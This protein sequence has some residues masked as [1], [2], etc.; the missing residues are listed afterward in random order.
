MTDEEMEEL[1]QKAAQEEI[2]M[3][4]DLYADPIELRPPASPEQIAQCEAFLG[5]AFP[6][7]YRHFLSLHNGFKTKHEW[8]F[9][10]TEDYKTATAQRQIALINR[11]G[12]DVEDVDVSELPDDVFYPQNLYPLLD[13]KV[14]IPEHLRYLKEFA[15]H[16][17][18]ARDIT[19]DPHTSFCTPQTWLFLPKHTLISFQE[20]NDCY[21]FFDT[22]TRFKDGEMNLLDYCC[23]GGIQGC[24][25]DFYDYLRAWA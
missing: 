7:S 2:E 24:Y 15:D 4:E 17:D 3:L 22:G 18:E 25:A 6:P 13:G 21:R 14:L 12:F 9:M 5:R 8:Y 16:F 1:L 10:G 20:D 19:H 23:D 11:I